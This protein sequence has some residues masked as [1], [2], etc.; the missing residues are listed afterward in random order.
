[1]SVF[2]GLLSALSWGTADFC[3]RFTGQRLGA[4]GALGGMLVAGALLLTII[5]AVRGDMPDPR[6]LSLWAAGHALAMLLALGLLY[7][8]LRRG[9]VSLVAPLSGMYPAWSLAWDVLNGARPALGAWIAMAAVMAGAGLVAR[10]EDT[11]AESAAPAAG[12]GSTIAIATLSGLLFALSLVCARKAV[13]LHGELATLWFGRG[14]GALLLLPVLVGLGSWRRL[15]WGGAGLL[16][17]QGGLDSAGILFLLAGAASG[18]TGAVATTVISSAFGV[19]TILWAFLLLR[20]RMTTA[21]TAGII[22]VFGGVA[23]LSALA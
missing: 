8:G 12:R 14:L 6:S 23:G 2:L 1:M 5:L 19:V 17:L 13:D 9:P 4:I 10:G 21:Q 15:T 20:E 11:P 3:A 18:G 22:L 7:E 16:T